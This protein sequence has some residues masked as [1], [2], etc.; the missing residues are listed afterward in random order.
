MPFILKL[1]T[2]ALLRPRINEL[3]MIEAEIATT[4]ARTATVKA[5]VRSI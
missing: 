1:L 2:S 4:Q 5:I 3:I